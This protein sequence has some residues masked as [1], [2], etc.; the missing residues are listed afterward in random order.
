MGAQA[1]R[2]RLMAMAEAEKAQGFAAAE[3]QQR[4]GEALA[5]AEKAQGLAQAQIRQAQ[6]LA[7]AEATKAQ[8]LAE[9]L[10]MEK[11]A[12]AWRNYNEAAVLQMLA[13]ILPEIARAI[14][15]PLQ[16]IDKITLINTG[17]GDS[18]VGL[19][20]ITNEITKVMAQVPP[21]IESL[22]GYRVEELVGKL[23]GGGGGAAPEPPAESRNPA[24]EK[25]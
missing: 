2:N 10:A 14:A 19:S 7:A 11:K 6:G 20:R 8:G 23:R 17:G 4:T 18:D 5:A 22:T 21:V 1:E 25:P 15:Q 24:Q 3:V 13:P 16:N 9:A 12:E